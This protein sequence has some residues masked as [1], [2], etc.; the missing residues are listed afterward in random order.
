MFM[1]AAQE[2]VPAP[3]IVRFE[4][5]KL[6]EIINGAAEE[7]TPPIS[8]PTNIVALAATILTLAEVT[9]FVTVVMARLLA[10]FT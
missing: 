1:F 5:P 4:S 2:R 6:P 9:L 3:V 10:S 7:I 8:S